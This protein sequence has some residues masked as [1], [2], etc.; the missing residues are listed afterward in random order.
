MVNDNEQCQWYLAEPTL[1]LSLSSRPPS[2]S[3]SMSFKTRLQTAQTAEF[4][5]MNV[6]AVAQSIVAREGPGMLFK[7]TG[8]TLLGYLV[9]GS[10]KYGFYEIFKPLVAAQLGVGLA[11]SSDV[12]KIVSFMIA[13]GCAELIG[14][15]FLAPFEAARIRLVSNPTF[16]PGIVGCVSRIVD[17]ETASSLFRGLPAIL[18]KQVPYTVVQLSSYEFLTGYVYRA[19]ESG[20]FGMHIDGSAP[21]T[22]YRLLI[23]AGCALVAALL[24]S[25]ASQPG[26]TLLSAVNKSARVA[27]V[28]SASTVP[29]K[30]PLAI[31]GETIDEL[32]I[33][34]LF[35]GTK[36]R[37]LHVSVIVVTQLLVY[38]FIKQLC[39]VPLTGTH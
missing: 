6:L 18:A 3:P 11:G 19:L 24:S 38:D 34:G 37:L 35:K 10:F 7:G 29:Q 1:T 16:A 8:P 25:L 15:T 39:G 13:G 23:S 28:G 22:Q 5:N 9:Q 36:A 26:D 4:V 31:M 21:A 33:K 12:D 17:E 20:T 14:S 2:F 30:G 32:G 27:A